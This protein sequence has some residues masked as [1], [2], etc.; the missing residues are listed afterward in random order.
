LDEWLRQAPTLHRAALPSR[1]LLSLPCR[2][3]RGAPPAHPTRQAPLPLALTPHSSTP[4]VAPIVG[5]SYTTCEPSSMRGCR[6]GRF[7]LRTVHV[8]ITA[9]SERL[10]RRGHRAHA[11]ARRD[12][13]PRRGTDGAAR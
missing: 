6:H 8:R 9:R 4:Q 7:H 3:P 5:R 10:E 13:P 12:R 1:R 2:R 11:T